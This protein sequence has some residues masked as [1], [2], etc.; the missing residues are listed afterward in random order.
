MEIKGW[1]QLGYAGG[2]FVIIIECDFRRSAGFLPQFEGIR[3]LHGTGRACGG[4]YEHIRLDKCVQGA[5]LPCKSNT[6]DRIWVVDFPVPNSCR[7]DNDRRRH[8]GAYGQI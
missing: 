5:W 8:V 3:I 6:P 7:S 2:V 1:N 4:V